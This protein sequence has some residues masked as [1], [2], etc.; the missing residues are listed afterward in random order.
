MKKEDYTSHIESNAFNNKGITLIALIITIIVML[1]LLGVTVTTSINGNLIGTTKQA[2]E[3]SRGM[4]VEKAK[5]LWL[6][7]VKEAEKNGTTP[8][9]LDTILNELKEEGLLS[10]EEINIIKESETKSITIGSRDISFSKDEKSTLPDVKI[11]DYINYD[12]NQRVSEENKEKLQYTSHYGAAGDNPSNGNG[13]SE[14]VFT[15]NSSVKWRV[16]N[17]DES[18]VITLISETAIGADGKSDFKLDMG[19]GY[20]YAEEEI[21]NACAIYGYG[22]GADKTRNI[23]YTIGGP[24]DEQTKTIT[25]TGAR[26]IKISDITLPVEYELEEITL[27]EAV[28]YPE[29][30]GSETRGG[31][32]TEKQATF[33]CIKNNY[34]NIEKTEENTIWYEIT[35]NS[36]YWLA[37]RGNRDANTTE[38][39]E[40][41]GFCV[42][43]IQPYYKSY[44]AASKYICGGMKG[45]MSS[46]SGNVG[47]SGFG[48]R[49]LVTLRKNIK[50]EKD[51]N[52]EN[53]WILK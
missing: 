52:N 28:Y 48:I 16:F 37:T 6:M 38:E 1:I 11:G 29:I 22:Y 27:S 44:R 26:S 35:M 49:P 13:Q 40:Y 7:D 31:Q 33:N 20:M 9:D 14:Q 46:S 4:D 17:V 25:G 18:G 39:G 23:T 5:E 34:Y 43:E 30:N 8:K 21:Q 32:S 42:W 15:A 51:P 10:E 41:I 47:V 24:F 50:L 2:T 53:S 36:Q 19:I 3:E 45:K 12:P